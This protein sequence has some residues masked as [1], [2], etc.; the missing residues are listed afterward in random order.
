MDIKLREEI[1]LTR[2]EL[3]KSL[4]IFFLSLLVVGF[5]AYNLGYDLGYDE[6]KVT[7]RPMYYAFTHTPSSNFGYVTP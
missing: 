5:W 1:V 4:V 7:Y 6:I 2:E 3:N